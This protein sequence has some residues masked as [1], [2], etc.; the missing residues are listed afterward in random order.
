MNWL[1]TGFAPFNKGQ[2]NSSQILVRELSRLEW[3]GQIRFHEPL[4]VTFAGAWPAVEKVLQ[5]H[6]EVQG[7]LALGQADGREKISLERVA[8][9]WMD[10][11]IP[12]NAGEQPR[13]RKIQAGPD[14]HWTN[15]PWQDF[16][17]Q[18]ECNLSYSAGTFVCNTLMYQLMDWALTHEKRAG[19]VHVPLLQS[20]GGP[21]ADQAAIKTLREILEFL[22]AL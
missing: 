10:A 4:P 5:S 20:Q 9:N 7:I 11:R 13:E 3:R 6:P 14:V 16:K 2:S 1:V 18:N 12:D 21:L 15:I 17:S 22:V 8:L 19:F